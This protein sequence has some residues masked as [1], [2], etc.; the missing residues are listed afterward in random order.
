MTR[1]TTIQELISLLQDTLLAEAKIITLDIPESI[2]QAFVIQIS[3]DNGIESWNLMRSLLN[4]TKCYPVIVSSQEYPHTSEDWEQSMLSSN[5]F[6][7]CFFE[8]E[9][10]GRDDKAVD[11]QN[12]IA[13]S[14]L[15]DIEQFME[16]DDD[17]FWD[18]FE[19]EE[20]AEML[21]V[22]ID[23]I[24]ERY[25]SAPTLDQLK[26]IVTGDGENKSLNLEKWVFEWEISHFEDEKVA[27]FK[28]KIHEREWFSTYQK[29]FALMLLPTGNGWETLAYLHW[30]GSLFLTSSGAIA[31]LKK[32]Y[33][34][35]QAELVCHYGTVI[36]LKVP[37]KP[38]TI[39]QAFNLAIEHSIFSNY[40]ISGGIRDYARELMHH[41][42]WSF[43]ERP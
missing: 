35:H 23:D 32:W 14:H 11:I 42:H 10:N 37:Q 41:H 27:I 29:H 9:V 5:F 12:I 26:E 22:Q 3:P 38:Q 30:Y 18:Q 17:Y 39:Q 20:R 4:Q 2:N 31:F 7:R 1:I 40:T 6:S 15:F 24:R 25:G 43:H 28:G 16:E 33:E 19:D 21:M 13:R 34:N 36:D 8:E